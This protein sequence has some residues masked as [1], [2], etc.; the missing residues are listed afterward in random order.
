MRRVVVDTNIVFSA[1]LSESLQ[2]REIL[3][4]EEIY[5]CAPNY[6][7]VEIFKHKERI[8]EKSKVTEEVIYEFL[9]EIMLQVEFINEDAITIRNYMKA[10][11]LCKGRV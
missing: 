8:V 6:L 4:N 9:G 11:Q 3:S 10:F 1:L 2:I 5:F 7:M